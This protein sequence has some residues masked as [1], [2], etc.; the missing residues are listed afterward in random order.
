[1]N[2]F[3]NFLNQSSS[4]SIEELNES[5]EKLNELNEKLNE[6]IKII[7]MKSCND[8]KEKKIGKLTEKYGNEQLTRFLY[9]CKEY[10]YLSSYIKLIQFNEFKNVKYLAKGGFGEVHKATWVS[11]F[12]TYDKKYEEKDVVLKKLYNS[13]NQI[14][15]I[16][17]EV[18]FD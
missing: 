13:D 2:K 7:R 12:N 18:N 4:P 16:L 15:D 1:M 6:L 8:C 10:S 3:F 14:L 17:S 11:Y 5:I 9:E